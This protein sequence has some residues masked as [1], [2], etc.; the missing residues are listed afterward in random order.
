MHGAGV[1][2]FLL[3]LT[4]ELHAGTT[5]MQ[6]EHKRYG[7]RCALDHIRCQT[8]LR[9]RRRSFVHSRMDW[10]IERLIQNFPS[11]PEHTFTDLDYVDDVALLD[12]DVC[13]LS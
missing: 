2:N 8:G 4:K 9:P 3:D 1:P 10:I 7:H 6:G 12:C 13:V 11:P 5:A